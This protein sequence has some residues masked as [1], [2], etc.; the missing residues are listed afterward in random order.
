MK[1]L[2]RILSIVFLALSMV[3]SAVGCGNSKNASSINDTVENKEKEPLVLRLQGGDWGEPTPYKHYPRGPGM[4]KMRLIFDSLLEKDENGIIPWIAESY[5]IENDGKEYIF[6]IRKDIKWQDGEELTCDDVKF[7]FEYFIKHP[8]V[9]NNLYISGKSFI[10]NIE[11]LDENKVKIKVNKSS[12]VHLEKLGTVRIIPKHIWEKVDDPEKFDSKEAYV[13]CGPFTLKE[14]NKEQ[15][16]YKFEAFKDYW[17]PKQKVDEI[18][19]IPVSNPVLAFENGEIDIIS[20]T[21]DIMSRYKG[22]EEYKLVKSP[23]F[24]GYRLLLNMDKKTGLK[25]KDIRHA[26]AY[27]LDKNELVEKV[28]RGAAV[29]ASAGYLPEDHIWYNSDVKKYNYDIDKA[30]DLLKD[31]KF[32]LEFLTGNRESEVKIAELIKINLEKI[33]IDV[34][35]KSVDMKTRDAKVKEK[36]YEIALIGHGGWGGDVDSLRR[37][38][39]SQVSNDSLPTSNVISGYENDV[40]NELCQNQ[41]LQMNKEKRKEIIFQLQEIISDEIPIIPLYNTTTYRVYRPSKYDEWMNMYD[42]HCVEHS[43]LSYLE[44]E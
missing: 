39:A 16:M 13:G 34:K 17:G 10:E 28:A 36:D 38:Y 19:F 6:N 30:D 1:N 15:G 12:A 33:G 26:I 41:M 44:R 14:Y 24:W 27:A 3:L 23:A 43:K 7:S 31:R 22:N 18:D 9:I 8:P 11:V 25:D 2:W 32:S 37:M 20:V 42:H 40:I 4:Y 21:P 5:N 29:P 35:I